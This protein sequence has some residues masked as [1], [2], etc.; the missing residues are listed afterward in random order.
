MKTYDCNLYESHKNLEWFYTKSA[1]QISL[2][3]LF[4]KVRNKIWDHPQCII[5]EACDRKMPT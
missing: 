4:Q 5:T 2:P 1:T 3:L